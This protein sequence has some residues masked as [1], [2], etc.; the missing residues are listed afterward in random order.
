MD[1]GPYYHT[2]FGLSRLLQAAR[3]L[4]PTPLALPTRARVASVDHTLASRK[5]C[6]TLSP[7]LNPTWLGLQ[8]VL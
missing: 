7:S 8:D 4:L 3:F 2:V 5:Q 1:T 6:Q